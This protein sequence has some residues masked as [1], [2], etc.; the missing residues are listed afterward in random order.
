[1]K[2]LT[3]T[4]AAKLLKCHPETIRQKLKSSEILAA[5]VGRRWVI[6]ERDIESYLRSLHNPPRRTVQTQRSKES[7][8][9]QSLNAVLRTTY[10]S[11]Q[12]TEDALN[13]LLEPRTAA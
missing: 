8:S 11:T 2:T 3:L 6:M 12:E 7:V 4:E 13:S 10:Q 5:K 1:M 9:C